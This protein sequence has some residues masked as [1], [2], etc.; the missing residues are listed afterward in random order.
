M[1]KRNKKKMDL[2][3]EWLMIKKNWMALVLACIF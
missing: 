3:E 2:V 1:S